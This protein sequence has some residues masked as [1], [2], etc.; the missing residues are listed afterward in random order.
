MIRVA[1]YNSLI[2]DVAVGMQQSVFLVR[3]GCVANSD[4]LICELLSYDSPTGQRIPYW[5]Q[6]GLWQVAV[7]LLE[8]S[9]YFW[10]GG[11]VVFIWTLS[12]LPQEGK[13]VSDKVVAGCC[14]VTLLAA[15]IIYLASMC[16]LWHSVWC[17]K[18]LIDVTP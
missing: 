3:V 9:I 4:V 11:Y 18:D 1:W 15:A 6:L 16:R 14:F 12:D 10:L 8:W 2:L 17:H 5:G 7:A 13:Q